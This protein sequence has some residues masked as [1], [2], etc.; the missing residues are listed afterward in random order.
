MQCLMRLHLKN[1]DGGLEYLIWCARLKHVRLGAVV[2]AQVVHAQQPVRPSRLL[3]LHP[4]CVTMMTRAKSGG[5]LR[6][7]VSGQDLLIGEIA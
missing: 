3:Y 4:Q 2:V 1:N 7:R 5:K 6:A